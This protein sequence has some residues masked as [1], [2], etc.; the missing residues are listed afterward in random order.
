MIKG[1]VWP[2]KYVG[3]TRLIRSGIT[4]WRPGRFF[5]NFNDKV[6]QQEHSTIYSGLRISGMALSKQRDLP[7][8]LRPRKVNLKIGLMTYQE[9]PNPGR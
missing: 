8:F 7:A 3:V 1:I 6:S 9:R 4:N 2:F 5:K